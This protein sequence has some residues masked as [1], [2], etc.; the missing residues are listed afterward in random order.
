MK[1]LCLRSLTSLVLLL[2]GVMLSDLSVARANNLPQ[3]SSP[4]G[5]E[6]MSDMDELASRVLEKLKKA[7]IKT[8]AVTDFSQEKKGGH[9]A[10]SSQLSNSFIS[11]LANIAGD[12]LV[13]DRPH[14]LQACQQKKWMSI[15]VRDSL[16]FRSVAFASGADG[17]IQG[18]F[19]LDGSLVELSLK[20]V[21]PETENKIAEVKAKILMPQVPDD[22]P[23]VP[24]QDPVTGVFEAGVGGVTAPT[25]KYCP[26][27]GFS[28]ES[29][30]EQIR[31]TKSTFRITIRSDGRPVDIRLLQPAGYGLDEN[32]LAALKQWEFSPARLPNG[33]PV[34]SRVN[35]EI[36][37]HY[38]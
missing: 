18:T 22:P 21:S 37:F 19:K 34:S 2:L 30:Q 35:I 5:S 32:S 26:A 10:L 31:E 24:V 8:V 29:L 16:V 6:K 33:T 38:P 15:D 14:M 4:A 11:T 28:R 1:P 7:H 3:P 17:L 13:L 12:I 25:C 36:A 20:V 9:R 23:E 27:P